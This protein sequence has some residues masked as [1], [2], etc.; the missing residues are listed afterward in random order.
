MGGDARNQFRCARPAR[1]DDGAARLAF[2]QS[3]FAIRKG[4]A[5]RL[6]H[7]AVAGDA[8]AVENGPDVAIEI[9]RR[10][11]TPARPR[12]EYECAA[13]QQHTRQ[14]RTGDIGS[15]PQRPDLFYFLSGYQ[16]GGSRFKQRPARGYW[17]GPLYAARAR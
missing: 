7:A 1:N 9:D 10:R 3:L 4:D 12:Q 15:P 16:R 6:L 13:Y 8:L 11:V 17:P 14:E 2:A 5:G